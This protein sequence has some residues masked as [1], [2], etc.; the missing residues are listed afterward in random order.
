MTRRVFAKGASPTD[1]YNKA[2]AEYAKP[3]FL[4][5]S[6]YPTANAYADAVLRNEIH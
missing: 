5:K 4:L 1:R 6:L 3:D 2:L